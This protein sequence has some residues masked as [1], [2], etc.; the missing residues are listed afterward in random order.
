MERRGFSWSGRDFGMNLLR[1]R[2]VWLLAL[3]ALAF[4]LRV[5]AGAWWESR[6]PD[7]VRFG[8]GDSDGYWRLGQTL[9]RGEPYQYGSD[10]VFRAP[11][12][13][14]I[15]AALFRLTGDD[16][17]TFWARVW[18]TAVSSLLVV[19]VY[20]LALTLFDARAALLAALGAAIYPLLAA[21]GMLLLSEGPF[22]AVVPF[23][24]ACWVRGWRATDAKRAA[25]WLLG[26]GALAGAATLIRPGWLLFTP[27]AIGLALLFSSERKRHLA[28]GG[29]LMA[30]LCLVMTP[31]WARNYR[32]TGHF[33][34]TTL[35]VGASLYDGLSPQATG[36]SQMDFVPIL[37]D[38]LHRQEA[39]KNLPPE[40]FEY[41]FD[42]YLRRLA[43]DW[44]A[45]HPGEVLQL[46]GIKLARM[47]NV[48]PNEARFQSPLV[49]LGMTV[50][51]LP[52]MVLGLWGAWA[53]RRRGWPYL[54]CLVPAAY[55]TLLHLFFVSSIRYR[56]PAL[57]SL[58]VLAA[59]LI[60]GWWMV[61][62]DWK[63]RR[64]KSREARGTES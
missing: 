23:Q 34:P 43:I 5:A 29:W 64:V 56:Q 11:G 8:F 13:P 63:E 36:A 62:G 60:G 27:F 7:D 59:G 54:L 51:Y 15:L 16:P 9:A 50:T 41:R 2:A 45:A 35:Q 4:A 61:D 12:Y 17:A 47:W 44:A 18:T 26:A 30:G 14:L 38:R 55:L 46:A 3:V 40:G 52:V 42:Q 24:L 39:E 37:A 19:G 10:R 25:P 48:W 53:F 31:W 1:R 28:A 20:W 57:P 33:V 21:M 58:I 6:L 22:C 49:R 32:V